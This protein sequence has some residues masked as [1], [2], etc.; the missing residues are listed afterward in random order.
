MSALLRGEIVALESVCCLGRSRRDLGDL[1]SLAE[2]IKQ[3]G[4]LNPPVVRPAPEGYA[5]VAGHR[6]I[7][8]LRLLGWTDIPVSVALD[9]DDQLTALRMER[10]ENTERL[11]LAPSEAVAEGRKIE[12]LERVAAKS[13]Q[14][15]G[16]R[17][18]TE[19]PRVSDSDAREKPRRAKSAAAEAVGMK[20]DRYAAA[21]KVVDA[22]EDPKSPPSVRQAAAK[23]VEQMD[24]TG[25]VAAAVRA[26]EA[27]QHAAAID[28]VIEVARKRVPEALAEVERK[29]LRA[30]WSKSLAGAAALATFNAEAIASVLTDD[31]IAAARAACTSMTAVI[32][33]IEK[34]RRG[35]R[36]VGSANA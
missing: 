31:E 35:L 23:A 24:A 7:E 12:A 21:A 19:P 30:R 17:R 2:S 29:R 13:R 3:I 11:L 9:A 10:D 14:Q 22:A 28:T 26:V 15:S 5:L 1:A 8:A 20:R 27:A 33:D 25:N 16:L 34:S 18:G 32:N 4:L 6:R 36:L